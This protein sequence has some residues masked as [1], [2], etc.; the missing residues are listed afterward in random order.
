MPQTV[1]LCVDDDTILLESLYMELSQEFGTE[2]SIELANNGKEA[3]DLVKKLMQEGHLIAV[4]ICDYLM[5]DMRGDEVLHQVHKLSPQT[6]NIMLTG[7]SNFE[8]VANAINH[9]NLYRYITKPWQPS[10]L[11][12]TVREAIRTF[13]QTLRLEEQK[14]MLEQRNRELEQIKASLEQ[15]VLERTSQLHLQKLAIEA[16]RDKLEMQRNQ[17]ELINQTKDKFFSIIAHD[18]KGPLNSFIGFTTLLSQHIEYLT[19]EEIAKLGKD[20]DKSV[21]NLKNLIENLLTWARSQTG[22]LEFNFCKIPLHEIVQN[23]FTLFEPAAQ[24]KNIHLYNHTHQNDAVYAWADYNSIDTVVR[25]LLSNA[26]KFTKEEGQV[27]IKTYSQ[28]Y[29]SYIVVSDTGVGIPEE[30]Q[31]KIFRIDVKYS[32]KGTAGELGT[33]L[34]LML[35]HEFVVKNRGKIRLE[36]KVNQ[37]TTFIIELPISEPEE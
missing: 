30:I 28:N 17:L 9:A 11:K 33:G 20:L 5:P 37:G 8:G 3:L 25:N 23:N 34:G 22:A 7:H 4:V 12:L 36:S 19:T 2:H 29:H 1:L 35:C 18:L 21:K 10:D 6:R 14:Q 32:T 15:K 27:N 13:T 31:D 26:I 16:Q 24:G